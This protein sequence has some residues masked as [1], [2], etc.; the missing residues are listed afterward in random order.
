MGPDGKL[1]EPRM[2]EFCADFGIA[3]TEGGLCD[4]GLCGPPE[5]TGEEP[6]CGPPEPFCGPPEPEAALDDE[7]D[8][9]EEECSSAG[10]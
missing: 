4:P 3:W 5:P 7:M 8:G 9:E 10:R 6:F 2:A 1:P